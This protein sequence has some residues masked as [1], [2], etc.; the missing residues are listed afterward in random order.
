M[1]Q[2]IYAEA[3]E[4]LVVF[5]SE[6]PQRPTRERFDRWLCS[7]PEHVRAYLEQSAVWETI[8]SQPGAARHEL[9]A[10]IERARQIF[11]ENVVPIT[12]ASESPPATQV[13]CRQSRSPWRTVLATAAT[14]LLPIAGLSLYLQAP[15]NVYSTGTGEQRSILLPDG[16][17]IDL[18]ARSRVR[19]RFESAGRHVDLLEGQAFFRVARDTT[20]P[21]IVAVDGTR[22]RAVGTQ[23]DPN[24]HEA[25]V[26]EDT[27]DHPDNQV[28]GELQRGYRLHDRI[29]RPSL[30]R[31][32]NNPKEQ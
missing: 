5:R 31:V 1:N 27:A 21:F 22:V 3:S 16:S 32:A 11:P 26:H 17:T 13:P 10:L 30:V 8:R 12:P 20:R 19:V 4:W 28:I 15:R 9:Q 6:Q 18:N 7:S 25:V 29:I 23:F 24:V 14:L 2:K